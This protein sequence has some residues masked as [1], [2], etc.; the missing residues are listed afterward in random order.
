LG[1]AALDHARSTGIADSDFKR[2]CDAAFDQVY[3]GAR[4]KAP[5][6]FH[7]AN[8][9]LS[10]QLITTG[11]GC[12]TS[13]HEPF[14]EEMTKPAVLGD[15]TIVEPQPPS[16][17]TDEACDKSRL[18]VAYGLTRDDPEFLV[19]RLPSEIDDLPPRPAVMPTMITKDDM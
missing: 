14:I 17:I 7:P 10:V 15:W 16:H 2:A 13:V 5:S 1:A 11:G 6:L 19:P 4:R 9:K 3:G 18:L 12:Q 8:R